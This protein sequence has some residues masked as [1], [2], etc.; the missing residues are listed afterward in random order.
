MIGGNMKENTIQ[1]LNEILWKRFSD[2]ISAICKKP[3]KGFIFD[4]NPVT[5]EDLKSPEEKSDEPTTP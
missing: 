3:I 1:E 5:M 4:P 2:N